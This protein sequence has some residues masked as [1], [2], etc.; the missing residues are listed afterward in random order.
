MALGS[1]WRHDNSYGA[2]RW[3]KPHHYVSADSQ[4]SGDE[5]DAFLAAS[6]KEG[7]DKPDRKATPMTEGEARAFIVRLLREWAKR[8]G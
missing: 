3:K 4:A 1:Y 5:L 6:H 2:V 7:H 8:I